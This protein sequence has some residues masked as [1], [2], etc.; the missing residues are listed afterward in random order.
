MLTVFAFAFILFLMHAQLFALVTKAQS[1]NFLGPLLGPREATANRRQF[2]EKTLA[3]GR[4]VI[5]LQYGSNKGA[6]QSGMNFGK[7]RQ[8]LD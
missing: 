3:S 5:G 7:I 6:N 8:I 1:K 4:N 2:D